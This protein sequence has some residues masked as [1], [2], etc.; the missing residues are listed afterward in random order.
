MGSVP[1]ATLK[2]STLDLEIEQNPLGYVQFSP[3]NDQEFVARLGL[4]VI[5]NSS[6]EVVSSSR[7]SKHTLDILV[8]QTYRLRSFYQL[9][10]EL[11]KFET[12]P[13]LFFFPRGLEEEQRFVIQQVAY[14]QTVWLDLKDSFSTK[15]HLNWLPLFPKAKRTKYYL[16]SVKVVRKDIHL[17]ADES[18]CLTA[19]YPL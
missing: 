7:M 1:T 6:A 18:R 8:N 19:N 10:F 9:P 4:Q 13:L 11:N 3:E 16:C 14:N 15:L 5:P 12:L 17:V 2:H